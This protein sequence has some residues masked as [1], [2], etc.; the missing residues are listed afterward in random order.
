MLARLAVALVCITLGSG[1]IATNVGFEYVPERTYYRTYEQ[2]LPVTVRPVKH[3]KERR[4]GA[5]LFGI[6]IARPDIHALV[7][8]SL[9]GNPHYYV[10]DLS[11][12]TE[13][14]GT[15]IFPA[16][17][18]YLPR[19]SIEYDVVEVSPWAAPPAAEP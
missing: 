16:P 8:E 6:E 3:V 19:T 11:L 2:F 15:F 10:S 13:I 18:L 14:H 17:M 9:A 12:V 7:E 1:C 4:W 5:H